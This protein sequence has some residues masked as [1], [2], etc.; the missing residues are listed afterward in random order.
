M[1]N[2]TKKQA[3][4]EERECKNRMNRVTS[5]EKGITKQSSEE[6][7]LTGDY[8]PEPFPGRQHTSEPLL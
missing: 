7:E 3:K 1:A 2:G 4:E 5:W 6:T 8:P